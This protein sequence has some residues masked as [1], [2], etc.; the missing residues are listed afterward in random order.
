MIYEIITDYI[1]VFIGA[2]TVIYIIIKLIIISMFKLGIESSNIFFYSLRK[3]TVYDIANS[4]S[5][6]LKRFL[7]V[8][9][10]VNIVFYTT[11]IFALVLYLVVIFR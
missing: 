3:A 11:G 6:N 8:S 2:L 4:D 5:K 9:N 7:K 10:W 1:W